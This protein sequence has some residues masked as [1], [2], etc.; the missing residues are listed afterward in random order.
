MIYKMALIWNPQGDNP[1]SC[2]HYKWNTDVRATSK[3]ERCREPHLKTRSQVHDLSYYACDDRSI[4]PKTSRW[5]KTV[6][7]GAD[8]RTTRRWAPMNEE[9]GDGRRWTNNVAVGADEWRTWRWA[10][11]N[12]RHDDGHEQRDVTV[13]STTQGNTNNWS[14]NPPNL[15]MPGS[16]PK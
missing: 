14:P 7:M 11:M 12:D 5:T 3:R 4:I 1:N 8:E 16:Q 6:A 2:V 10:P 15:K 13:D 9:R